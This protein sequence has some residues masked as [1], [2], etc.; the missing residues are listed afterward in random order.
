VVSSQ[1]LVFAF[2]I[3]AVGLWI[4]AQTALT[5]AAFETLLTVAGLAVLVNL[6]ATTVITNHTA[7]SDKYSLL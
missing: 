3:I 1:N 4:L 2:F 7:L 6:I 5:G